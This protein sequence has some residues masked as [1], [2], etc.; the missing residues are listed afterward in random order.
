MRVVLDCVLDRLA[1]DIDNIYNSATFN[2]RHLQMGPSHDIDMEW[3]DFRNLAVLYGNER[4]SLRTALSNMPA[5]EI[6]AKCYMRSFVQNSGLMNMC[7]RPIVVT[8]VDQVLDCARCII[9]VTAHAAQPCVKDT[10]IEVTSR[11]GR[12]SGDKVLGDVPLSEALAMQCDGV[13]L[14]QER[15]WSA[16]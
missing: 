9:G 15:F 4:C 1:D 7:K 5:L 3:R 14:E 11:G 16:R 10:D 12:I 6:A 13:F 2:H 8:L